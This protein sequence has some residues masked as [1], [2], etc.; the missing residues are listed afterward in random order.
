M[1][2]FRFETSQDGDEHLVRLFGDFDITGFGPVDEELRRIQSNGRP[3]V[4]LDLRGLTFIDSSGIRA[5]LRADT[6]AR[7]LGKRL[8][9][10]AGPKRVHKVFQIT[11]LDDQLEFVDPED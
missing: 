7:T 9:L 10:I 8:R 2:D 3:S 6:R 5:V 1:T 11:R 4:T